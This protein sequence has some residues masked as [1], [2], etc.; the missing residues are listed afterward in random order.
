MLYL[1][2][3][4][5]W[6]RLGS[7]AKIFFSLIFVQPFFTKWHLFLL[8]SLANALQIVHNKVANYIN[9]AVILNFEVF[10]LNLLALRRMKQDQSAMIC[11]SLLWLFFS[12]A[13]SIFFMFLND[14]KTQTICDWSIKIELISSTYPQ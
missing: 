4:L 5:V 12:I 13:T 7:R 2:L 8:P 1:P 6:I 3:R 14:K 9:L 11:A 10:I